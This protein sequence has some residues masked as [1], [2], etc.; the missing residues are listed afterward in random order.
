M[1]MPLVHQRDGRDGHRAGAE[2]RGH[3]RGADAVAERR[4][5][6]GRQ[7]VAA[8]ARAPLAHIQVA[9]EKTL[10]GDQRVGLH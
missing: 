10:Q 1:R 3:G 5:R 2:A 8:C 7:V 9:G 6:V 4:A